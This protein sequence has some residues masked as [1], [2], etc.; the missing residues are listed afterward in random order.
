MDKQ[1]DTDILRH[2]LLG[3]LMG[4]GAYGGL[5]LMHDISG[6]AQKPQKSKDELEI[7]LPA[8]RLPK[9]AAEAMDYLAPFIASSAGATGGFLGASKLY[10]L[11]KKKQMAHEQKQVEDQYMQTLQQAHQKVGSVQTPLI[12]KFLEG[13]ITK[14][15]EDLNK[16]G[17]M[18][19]DIP[20]EG[21]T[22]TIK[23]Q[24]GKLLDSAAHSDLGA[25]IIAAW[26]GTA[27]GAGGLTYS[28]A[29]NMDKNKA[30]AKENSALPSEIRLNTV[31]R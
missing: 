9:T 25:G 20:T 31:G 5:R 2:A 24:G 11:M 15:G 14:V 17:F 23:H 13:L 19:P 1:A 3:M 8:S 29:R 6:A 21:I 18:G 7:T 12:D 30:K 28:I 27:L 10:E 16:Q 22:D 4:G 26:L